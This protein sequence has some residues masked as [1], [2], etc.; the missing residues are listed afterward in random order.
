MM[1]LIFDN[2]NLTKM[3]QCGFNLYI[4]KQSNKLIKMNKKFSIGTLY[5]RY[6]PNQGVKTSQANSKYTYKL[7]A[8]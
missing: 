3:D 6:Q 5:I 4:D 2:Y 1:L 8:K 7:T